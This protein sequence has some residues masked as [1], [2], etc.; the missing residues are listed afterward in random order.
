MYSNETAN[1]ILKENGHKPVYIKIDCFKF[2]D[3][4]IHGLTLLKL[5]FD[6]EGHKSM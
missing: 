2:D 3:L 5:S 4:N 1:K 6:L